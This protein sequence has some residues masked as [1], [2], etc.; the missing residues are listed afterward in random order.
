[1]NARELSRWLAAAGAEWEL[2]PDGIPFPG[3]LTRLIPATS[4]EPIQEL[5]N[6]DG[7]P[8]LA[9]GSPR[10]RTTA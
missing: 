3:D 10:S 4:P 7:G 6:S 2:I 8:T 9:A 1:M 5:A